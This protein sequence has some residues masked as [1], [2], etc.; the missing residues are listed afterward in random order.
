MI[1]TNPHPNIVNS[2]SLYRPPLQTI[3]TNP[4]QYN[5]SGTNTHKTRHS[6]HS[7]NKMLK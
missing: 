5:L 4:L 1:H 2:S 3:P 6:I 7:Q